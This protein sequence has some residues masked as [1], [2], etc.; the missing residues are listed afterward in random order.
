LPGHARPSEQAGN[1]RALCRSLDIDVGKTRAAA[2]HRAAGRK[3]GVDFAAHQRPQRAADLRARQRRAAK[4]R[5]AA[6]QQCA[7]ERRARHAQKKRCHDGFF[8]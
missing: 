4:K 2:L 8:R 6:R 3:R 7:A 5:N 1:R